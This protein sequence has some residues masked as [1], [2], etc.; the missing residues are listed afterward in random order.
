M[1]AL[2]RAGAF[3]LLTMAAFA[4]TPPFLDRAGTA[5]LGLA[6]LALAVGRP[7]VGARPALP[8]LPTAP[9]AVDTDRLTAEA[10]EMV[11]RLQAY[12][13]PGGIPSSA[14]SND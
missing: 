7:A 1:T 14:R 5:A 8:F 4:W 3:T 13:I 2:G 10:S 11:S 6:F 12:G 9:V